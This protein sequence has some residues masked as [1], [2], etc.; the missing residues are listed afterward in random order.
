MGES[1][2]T[3]VAKLLKFCRDFVKVNYDEVVDPSPLTPAGTLY[4]RKKAL[5]QG[6]YES[7]RYQRALISA[8][9]LIQALSNLFIAIFVY[10]DVKQSRIANDVREWVKFLIETILRLDPND[11]HQTKLYNYLYYILETRRKNKRS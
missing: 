4:T 2:K 9:P 1:S 8:A 6:S 7:A 5:T 11:R 10:G 3:L